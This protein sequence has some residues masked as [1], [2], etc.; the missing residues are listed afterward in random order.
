[1]P[2]I[3]PPIPKFVKTFQSVKDKRELP[4]VALRDAV[5]FP[6]IALPILV[7]RPKSL[8]ALDFAMKHD[9]LAFFVAQKTEEHDKPTMADMYAVGVIGKIKEMNRAEDGAVR[10]LIEGVMRAKGISIVHEDP[11]VRVRLEPLPPPLIKKTEKIE[12]LMY[13][14]INQFREIVS[15][16]APVPLDVLFVILNITDPWVLGDLIASNLEFKV[17]ERQAI[18]EAVTV[19]NK[20]E[21]LRQ[22]LGRQAQVLRQARKLQ[23]EVGKELDKMQREVF[24]REQLKAIEKELGM[25]GGRNEAEE[26]KDKIEK[27]GMTQEAKK[28]ALEELARIER[29]PSFSPEISYI[30]TYLDWLVKLPWSKKDESAIDVKK[31]QQVLDDDH[32]GLD[33]VKE[34]M[35]EYLSVQK[36]VGKIRGPILCF[37]GPPGTGKTSIGKSIARALGRKFVRMSL[38][39]VRDEAEIRGFRRTYVGALPGRIVQGVATAGTRNP[40]FMLDEVDKMGFDAFR[41]DPSAA[42]LE[43]LDPEQNNAFSDHYLEVPFDLSDVMFITTANLLDPI[44]P[45]L[46]DRMEVI[47]FAGYTEDEKYWIAQKFLIPKQIKDNGLTDKLISFTEAAVRVIIREYTLEAGVRELERTIAAVCRKVARKVAENGGKLALRKIGIDDLREFLGP[48]KYRITM[49]EKEDEV[50]VVNGLAWTSAGG[51]VLHIEATKVPGK[52]QL[53]LTGHLGQVMQESAQAAFTYARSRA[54][55]LAIKDAF[56]KN[57]DLHV[58][59]PS[60][61]IPKD[62]PSAGVAMTLALISALTGRPV[63]KDVA[64]TGEITLRGKVMEIGGVKEKVI[65]AHRGQMT[66]VLLPKD[67]EKD[68]VDVPSQVKKELKFIFAENM[69][70]VLKVALK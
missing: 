18:L 64:M 17:E 14:A 30:R 11:F 53:I 8:A 21:V 15:M 5:V 47:E 2:D 7:Q 35:V 3:Q 9:H 43:A 40:V 20:L 65:A 6:G 31:A 58:H 52:G 22:A 36:L 25:A 66:A 12:A 34:R 48:Q 46:K 44:P 55:K 54:K 27:A 19:E 62:G 42:L 69:D 16:G 51:D 59:V 57:S 39:G 41:G 29:M 63:R 37:V 60:G 10:V 70:E 32:F 49:A 28:V 67:N 61:A 50:G 38:G 33:K 68:M 24:L 26:L 13:S 45:A 4:L 56:Y 1:M 23:A